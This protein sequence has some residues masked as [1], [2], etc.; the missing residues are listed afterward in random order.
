MM[1]MMVMTTIHILSATEFRVCIY[2]YYYYC[3][4]RYFCHR[5]CYN[6]FFTICFSFLLSPT[7]VEGVQN[8]LK[9]YPNLQHTN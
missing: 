3:Y 9:T 4:R 8:A 7:C 1:M 2:L 5:Y 6:Y